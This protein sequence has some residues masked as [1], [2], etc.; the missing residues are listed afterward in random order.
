VRLSESFIDE[1]FN[2]VGY[3]SAEWV[4][5]A[6]SETRLGIFTACDMPDIKIVFCLDDV[7]FTRK[8]DLLLRCASRSRFHAM[9]ISSIEGKHL[10]QT[11]QLRDGELLQIASFRQNHKGVFHDAPEKCFATDRPYPTF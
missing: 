2:D 10:T 8:F 9:S 6:E 1:F 5:V 11:L 3:K 4:G 7:R